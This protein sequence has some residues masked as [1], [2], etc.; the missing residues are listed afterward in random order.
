MSAE[1]MK[2]KF[3]RPPSSVVR[4]S[5]VR[6]SVASIISEVI[7]W[8]FLKF[9]LWLFMGHIS[10]LFSF[11]KKNYDFVRIFFPWDPMG[12]KTWNAT[13]PSNHFWIRPNGFWNF[14]S[15]VLTKVPLWIFEI[16]IFAFSGF[17]FLFSLTW[18]PMGAK[19]SKIY[20]SLKSLLNPFK[21]CLNFLLVIL[22]KVLVWIFKILSFWFLTNFWI[23]HLNST[24]K[25]KTSTIWKTSDR[26]AKRS[27]IW[28]SGVSVQCIKGTFDT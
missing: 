4:A 16:L 1:L 22:T 8:I 28:A 26:S 2:S 20:S 18:D 25:Q 7:A 27:E 15:V 21:L 9:Y 17:F 3:I 19:T 13:P 24:G 10:R 12:A 14:F 5:L 11:L 6:P 23:S